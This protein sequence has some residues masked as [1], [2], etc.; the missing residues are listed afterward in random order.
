MFPGATADPPGAGGGSPPS[1]PGAGGPG[2]G[3]LGG[4][5]GGPEG[6]G[7]SSSYLPTSQTLVNA[8]QTGGDCGSG[9]TY[10]NLSDDLR[11]SYQE[12]DRSPADQL[13]VVILPDG[14]DVNG[15]ASGSG[16]PC[17]TDGS[18]HD[19]LDDGPDTNDGDATCRQGSVN[20]NRVGTTL[21]NPSWTDA[22]DVD[23]FTVRTSAVVKKTASQAAS[24]AVDVRIGS[25]TYKNG[26]TQATTTTYVR[27]SRTDNVNPATGAEWTAA[28]VDGLVAAARCVDC[29]PANRATQLQ[30]SVDAVY[31]AEHALEVRF[32]WSGVPV[33]AEW[34]YL[35]AECRRLTPGAENV[36][37][38]VGQGGNPPAAWTT[39]FTCASDADSPQGVHALS[40]SELNSGAPVVRLWDAQA[41]TPDDTVQGTAALDVLRIVVT[42]PPPGPSRPPLSPV[43][44]TVETAARANLTVP[45]FTADRSQVGVGQTVRFFVAVANLGHVL[46]PIATLTLYDNAILPGSA[47]AS[48]VVG[49]EDFEAFSTLSWTASSVGTHTIYAFLDPMD[50]VRESNESDNVRSLQVQV[51]G[52]PTPGPPDIMVSREDIV[53]NGIPKVNT[54]NSMNV[55]VHN[56]GETS[57]TNVHVTVTVEETGREVANFTIPVLAA[58]G[59]DTHAFQWVPETEGAWHLITSTDDTGS[60]VEQRE[61][62]N[63]AVSGIYVK[64]AY[65]EYPC[66]WFWPNCF[67]PLN[68]ECDNALLEIPADWTVAPGGTMTLRDCVL[69][70]WGNVTIRGTLKAL[71][72]P[73]NLGSSLVILSDSPGERELRVKPNAT[74]EWRDSRTANRGFFSGNATFPSRFVVEDGANFTFVNSQATW[75]WGDPASKLAPGGVQVYSSTLAFTGS[76]VTEGATHGLYLGQGKSFGTLSGSNTFDTNGVA[77]L[78]VDAGA[79]VNVTANTFSNNRYGILVNSSSPT[80][81]GDTFTGN[82]Y[83]LRVEGPSNATLTSSVATFQR[84]AGAW[85]NGTGA[86]RPRVTQLAW[87]SDPGTESNRFGIYAN[88][89]ALRVDNVTLERSAQGVV[90]DAAPS[91]SILE[92]SALRSWNFSVVI[93]NGAWSRVERNNLT[94]PYLEDGGAIAR[95]YTGLS[96]T[97][98]TCEVRGTDLYSLCDGVIATDAASLVV[99]DNTTMVIRGCAVQGGLRVFD[100]LATVVGNDLG[101]SPF[102]AYAERSPGTLVADNV[103][104]G[105]VQVMNSPGAVIRNNDMDGPNTASL[106]NYVRVYQSPNAT[107]TL[108]RIRGLPLTVIGGQYDGVKYGDDDGVE[109]DGSRDAVI[110]ENT[111]TGAKCWLPGELGPLPGT[112]K[113][114]AW[115]K[116]YNNAS[117]TIR[118]NVMTCGAWGVS[119]DDRLDQIARYR[120]T[121]AL[122]EGNSIEY[123]G[124]VSVGVDSSARADVRSNWINRSRGWA[125]ELESGYPLSPGGPGSSATG[126][127]VNDTDGWN[128]EACDG[129][130]ILISRELG[131][132]GSAVVSGNHVLRSNATAIRRCHNKNA[133]IHNNTLDNTGVSQTDAGITI[134]GLGNPTGIP[135]RV[136]NNTVTGFLYGVW[137]KSPVSLLDPPPHHDIG[138]NRI[139]DNAEGIQVGW[140]DGYCPG[141][142]PHFPGQ[143]VTADWGSHPVSADLH[144]NVIEDN[145]IGV[146]ASAAN[147]P[148]VLCLNWGTNDTNDFFWYTKLHVGRP[149]LRRN[150]IANGT[151]GVRVRFYNDN[152]TIDPTDPLFLA[153]RADA[154]GNTIENQTRGVHLQGVVFNGTTYPVHADL[155]DNNTIANNSYGV[156]I[157]AGTANLTAFRLWWNDVRG[158]AQQ[159]V[160]VEGDPFGTWG[161]Y[162][163]AECNWWNDDLGP[164]DDTDPISGP[165]D[166][167]DNDPGQDVSD[168]FW[169]RDLDNDPYWL[170]EPALTAT[171]CQGP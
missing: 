80:L 7:G 56:I 126:N 87:T 128:R 39:A 145:G 169:Y 143:N 72:G 45:A 171:T 115:V 101:L 71:K 1:P 98:S 130:A 60:V 157:D 168:Y 40:A 68:W 155:H 141:Q 41:D 165:P 131:H 24:I 147:E 31:N 91:P 30:A 15:W 127:W 164:D 8:T 49:L 97:G 51:V 10:L 120:D 43:N 27:Y 93:V 25:G 16:T 2:P 14:S 154:S 18:P 59:Q 29:S 84:V 67:P 102:P 74:L 133:Y 107:V 34:W 9:W 73:A 114:Y 63:V 42:L 20:G 90:F 138:Y 35:T 103:L 4:G 135:A 28:D 150:V 22:A 167:N 58:T 12:V 77:G 123:A 118:G 162:F 53:T 99:A 83:G 78:F 19:E 156:W 65:A 86:G 79:T 95:N 129:T 3:P 148:A 124:H 132:N 38:Q 76:R 125:I 47:I 75:A 113:D 32:A 112:F 44:A 110:T 111:F 142:P 48:T 69:I 163:H 149:I 146:N 33:F 119:M 55:T 66:A 116:V 153:P 92:D 161:D 160:H 64:P 106:Q 37:I 100:S 21:A 50:S 139:R 140:G 54:T 57:A 137:V 152:A 104:I 6:G 23:D 11:C 109:L 121:H 52:S 36:L 17:S 46:A 5:G 170:Q 82:G 96:C 158:N 136:E 159:G 108:N 166:Q 81:S 13:G 88:A 122:I 105:P 89:S 61:D 117:A 85:F 134:S 70:T 62:N 26:A 151:E 94:M 144:D